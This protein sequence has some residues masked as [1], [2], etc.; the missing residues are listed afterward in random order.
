MANLFL[1]KYF[2][3]S[4]VTRTHFI[5]KLCACVCDGWGIF[6]SRP[7]P[8]GPETTGRLLCG[9][10]QREELPAGCQYEAFLGRT[11]GRLDGR[12]RPLFSTFPRGFA[13]AH[14]AGV[15]WRPRKMENCHLRCAW[16][17]LNFAS[18]HFVL[19]LLRIPPACHVTLFYLGTVLR[20]FALA[21]CLGATRTCVWLSGSVL[22]GPN[23]SQNLKR[24]AGNVEIF[25]IK[26][27]AREGLKDI[28]AAINWKL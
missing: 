25:I 14:A 4:K 2:V 10:G 17:R 8:F 11:Y 24:S 13:W 23:C 19:R 22:G 20:H 21:A 7:Q 12:H 5:N 15:L 27:N 1:P 28:F 16:A 3:T 26:M 18:P 6:L 9:G